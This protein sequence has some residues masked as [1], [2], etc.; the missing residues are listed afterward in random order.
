MI[1][2]EDKG[3]NIRYRITTERIQKYV[4]FKKQTLYIRG[5]LRDG[6]KYMRDLFLASG[7]VQN[8]APKNRVKIAFKLYSTG[9][10]AYLLTGAIH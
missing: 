7:V 8:L 5:F 10:T 1:T 4:I 3:N 2:N 6:K 9:D